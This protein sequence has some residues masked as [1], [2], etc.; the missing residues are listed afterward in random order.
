MSEAALERLRLG[1]SSEYD[2]R[3]VEALDRVVRRTFTAYPSY[4][5]G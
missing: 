4:M 2:P 3:V 1:T 5:A